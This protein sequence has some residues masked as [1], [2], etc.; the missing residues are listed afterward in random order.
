M[1][2]IGTYADIENNPAAII[3]C[4]VGIGQAVLSGPYPIFPVESIYESDPVLISIVNKLNTFPNDGL[5]ITK[6]IMSE[7]KLLAK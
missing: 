2:I 6:W 4:K 7:L 5:T 3:K 1:T